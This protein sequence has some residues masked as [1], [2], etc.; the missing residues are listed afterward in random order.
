MILAAKAAL[1]WTIVSQMMEDQKILHRMTLPRTPDNL[2]NPFDNAAPA[3]DSTMVAENVEITIDGITYTIDFYSDG[4]NRWA[5]IWKVTNPATPTE[6][7]LPRC[8]V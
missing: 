6:Y 1:F 5:N 2:E 7:T 4:T 3:A 8:G